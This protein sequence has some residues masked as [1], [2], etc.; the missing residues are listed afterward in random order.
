MTGST[1]HATSAPPPVRVAIIGAGPSGLVT[2]KTLLDGMDRWGVGGSQASSSSS[3]SSTT[4]SAPPFHVEVSLFEQ[5]TQVGG[6]FRYRSY[7]SATLVSSKQLTSFSD[8]RM[9]FEHTDHLTL[10][11]YCDYLES[12]ATKFKL[13]ERAK[14]W[15]LGT[16]VTKIRK[17]LPHEDGN[18][19]ITWQDIASGKSKTAH[20]DALSLCTGLHVE[21]SIPEI[22]GL[23]PVAKDTDRSQD[24]KLPPSPPESPPPSLAH[25]SEAQAAIQTMHSSTFKDP[26]IF[27]DKRVMIMG[28]GETGMDL[29]YLAVKNGAKEIVLCTRGGFLSFPAVLSDFV[30]FGQRFEGKLPID[31]LISNLCETAYVHPW[32]ASSHLRWHISDT[33]L[34]NVVLPVLTGTKAGCNQWAGEL[35]AARQGRAYVFLN[36]SAKAM[37]YI[38]RPYKKR[39]RFMERIATYLDPPDMT[40]DEPDIDLAPFPK[41]VRPDGTVEFTR[42]GRKDDVRMRTRSIKPDVCVYATGYTQTFPFFDDQDRYPLPKDA[43]VRDIFSSKDP[44]VAFIGYVRPGVG[45]IPP[46][47]E[48][49]AQLWTMVLAGQLSPPTSAG[50][51]HLLQAPTA[52]ITYGVDH[53]SYVSSLARDM[54][55]SP[56]LTDLVRDYGMKTTL[57]YALGAAFN[58][59]Y[60]LE[61]PWKDPSVKRTVDTELWDTIVRRGLAG[62][63]TMA[64]FPILAYGPLNLFCWILEM[65]FN[66]LLFP[67]RLMMGG[68]ARSQATAQQSMRVDV[69]KRV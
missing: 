6:T 35:P 17:A 57:C 12:Y 28:T 43:D 53:S 14:R 13:A 68:R 3:S 42:N 2:A 18:H 66:V 32:I 29:S 26:S 27:K 45:G 16:R 69:R 33:V 11:E 64:I 39:N 22:P 24:S 67:L 21:P 59:F 4:S 34:R 61:G 54:G 9:P 60:R 55:T 50:H 23:P 63:G 38:N 36:K 30:V 62:N 20:F 56:G 44:S 5:E 49:Q 47:S 58:P 65:V 31:G 19:I 15:Q 1:A 51:Y 40:D 48:A 52:R 7:Q 8:H 41:L 25:L 10:P 46:L 37:P